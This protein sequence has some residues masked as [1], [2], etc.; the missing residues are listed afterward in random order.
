MSFSRSWRR[1]T[2][3]WRLHRE[4]ASAGFGPGQV[5]GE[6]SAALPRRL[7]LAGPKEPGKAESWFVWM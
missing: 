1:V 2:E 3:C 5:R 7:R 6:P 4:S